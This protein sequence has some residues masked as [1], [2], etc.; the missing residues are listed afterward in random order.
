MDSDL[1]QDMPIQYMLFVETE[2]ALHK[3]D[4]FMGWRYEVNKLINLVEPLLSAIDLCGQP[5]IKWFDLG[6]QPAEVAGLVL[7]NLRSGSGHVP[8]V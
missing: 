8:S 7:E 6:L 2:Q 1:E 4:E 3:G 5:Y